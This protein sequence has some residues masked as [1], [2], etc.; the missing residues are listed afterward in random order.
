MKRLSKSELE[1]LLACPGYEEALSATEDHF[2]CEACGANYGLFR[3][4]PVVL[5]EENEL[6]PASVYRE[7]GG[8]KSAAK[9]GMFH[10]LKRLVPGKSVN[11]AREMM[12]HRLATEHGTRGSVI[13]VVG[14]GNQTEQLEAHFPG[15][16]TTFVFCDID[17]RTDAD[18]FC[19]SHELS[20][21]NEVFD[22]VISTAVLEHVLY[23]DKVISEIHRVLKQ[24]GFIYSEI[25][26]LQSV[27]EG[28][29]DFTRFTMSGHRRL[30]E[31]FDELKTGMV[32]GPGTA[33]VW[34]IVDFFKALSPNR[35][36]SSFLGLAARAGFFWLKYFDYLMKDNLVAMDAA[37]CTY[38][39]G[40]KINGRVQATDIIRQYK[41]G[42]FKHV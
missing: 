12:F 5:R 7:D 23:P 1:S 32:A 41:G 4:R 36:V 22:G 16:G 19:D 18:V 3:D 34:S 31:F 24:D 35:R 40:T 8:D 17:K 42:N 21:R 15:D 29:Y 14:C 37:S 9:P 10:K 33:L 26:F 2:S 39:Y 13:L 27:H 6:F 25:P 20:F 28:A 30:M 11:L 38:F